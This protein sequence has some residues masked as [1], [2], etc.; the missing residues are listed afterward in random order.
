[1][2][3]DRIVGETRDG[4][5]FVLE[6]NVND[7]GY[8]AIATP[9]S[10]KAY[11]EA[12]TTWGAKDWAEMFGSAISVWSPAIRN[13]CTVMTQ[14]RSCHA[15]QHLR[16]PATTPSCSKRFITLVDG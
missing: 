12:Q 15:D 10:L 4:F 3:Q 11:F 6:G 2:W 13:R 7:V 14:C 1:M 8:Q 16:R 9:G 5:G